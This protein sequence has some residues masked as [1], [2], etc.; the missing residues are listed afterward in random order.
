MKK[1]YQF[2]FFLVCSLFFLSSGLFAQVEVNQTARYDYLNG[3]GNS[4]TIAYVITHEE[5]VYDKK[6]LVTLDLNG[7][8]LNRIEIPFKQQ[9]ELMNCISVGTKTVF[10]FSFSYG[11]DILLLVVDENGQ[12]VTRKTIEYLKI[13]GTDI[14]PVGTDK[15]YLAAGVKNKKQGISVECFDLNLESQWVYSKIPEKSKYFYSQAAVNSTGD[16]AVI[17]TV[18][19]V[20]DRVLFIDANGV[21]IGDQQ[22][23]NEGLKHYAL[24]K[25]HFKSPDEL[26]VFADYGTFNE[27]T[28]MTTP[29]G[30]SIKHFN[31]SGEEIA[32]QKL[33]FTDIQAQ[34]GN[35]DIN[36]ELVV[37]PT[38]SLRVVDVQN[39]NGK[40]T[41]ITESYYLSQR[42]KTTGTNPQGQA[43][44]E[45][46][47]ILTLMD[48]YLLE[49]DNLSASNS[50][51]IWKPSRSLS[52][53]GIKFYDATDFCDL[54]EKN[55]Y[56]GYQGILNDGILIRGFAQ[57]HE[58]FNQIPFGVNWE[59]VSTRTY[60]GLPLDGSFAKKNYTKN[61][62]RTSGIGPVSGMGSDGFIMTDNHVILYRYHR[63]TYNLQFILIK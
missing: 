38:P 22:I 13:F 44:V 24:Y 50:E 16:I 34:W 35:L 43:T 3:V 62:V 9:P 46:F 47:K 8:E 17:Y 32:D 63:P 5:K 12:E 61:F 21:E 2:K 20:D 39:I 6:I 33:L 41:L 57:N 10:Y 56:F 60:F 27:E 36:N 58:Y 11:K 31:K 26:L 29:E 23:N 49:L 28:F 51:R 25:M 59:D 52:I 1:V 14:I 54:L 4:N 37:E 15:F 7:K 19:S 42:T 40:S 30:L 18:K 53:K 45:V 55:N 48:L